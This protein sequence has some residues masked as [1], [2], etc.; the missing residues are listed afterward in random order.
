MTM[1]PLQSNFL[2]FQDFVST[3]NKLKLDKRNCIQSIHQSLPIIKDRINY[4]PLLRIVRLN[5]EEILKLK[6]KQSH[7]RFDRNAWRIQKQMYFIY[8]IFIKNSKQSFQ[9]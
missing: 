2:T 6:S 5:N 7:I 9:F 4:Y 3:K 8:F 1:H